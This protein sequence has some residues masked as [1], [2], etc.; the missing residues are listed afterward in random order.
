MWAELR[1]NSQNAVKLVT[2]AAARDPRASAP[3]V[4]HESPA[5]ASLDGGQQFGMLAMH[6][7]LHIALQKVRSGGLA[8]VGVHNTSTSE[9]A[10]GCAGSRL[11]TCW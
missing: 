6:Q 10:L 3:R 2:G 11:L 1:G 4:V 8:L 9:G 5:S 7:A